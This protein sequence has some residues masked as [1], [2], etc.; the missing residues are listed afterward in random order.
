MKKLKVKEE[1]YCLVYSE[2]VHSDD[3]TFQ[4]Y[5]D[6]ELSRLQGFNCITYSPELVV[7]IYIWY[8][9]VVHACNF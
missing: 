2:K 7:D 9:I 6:H 3:Y 4:I 5:H 8:S 1:V